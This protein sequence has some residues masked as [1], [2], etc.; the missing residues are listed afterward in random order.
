MVENIDEWKHGNYLI[1]ARS[2]NL[3]KIINMLTSYE[4]SI[5]SLRKQMEIPF[6]NGREKV[7]SKTTKK[8]IE[9]TFSQQENI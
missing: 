1:S 9:Y 8:E 5:K 6:P 4:C 2:L 3:L 7:I